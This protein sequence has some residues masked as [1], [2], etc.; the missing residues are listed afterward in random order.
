ML[1]FYL[2]ML[3][4][5]EEKSRFEHLYT[6]Y[7]SVLYNYAYQILHNVD[8]SEDAVHDTFMKLLDNMK[9]I[10]DRSDAEARNY[11]IIIVK[12]MAKKYYGHNKHMSYREEVETDVLDIHDIEV[13][14]IRRDEAKRLYDLIMSLDEKYAD[15][16]IM[17]YYYDYKENEIAGL[18]GLT[19]NNVKIRLHRGK[20]MLKK[21]LEKEN[22]YDGEPV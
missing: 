10:Q 22:A 7:K 18:L 11:L 8:L 6:T 14:A 13:E 12:N 21:A 16:L 1:M 17:K 5:P 20:E 19:L 15:V 4:T 3:E 2:S 9:K